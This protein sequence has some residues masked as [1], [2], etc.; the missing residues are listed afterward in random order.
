MKWH[1]YP[2][3][4]KVEKMKA[5]DLEQTRIETVMII[6]SGCTEEQ[7]KNINEYDALKRM[8]INFIKNN[9]E[10]DIKLFVKNAV[11]ISLLKS[12]QS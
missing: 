9:T 3:E 2:Q 7:L 11:V 6:L 4:K 10:E 5:E 12:L 8:A 1:K